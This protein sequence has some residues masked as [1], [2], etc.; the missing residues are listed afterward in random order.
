MGMNEIRDAKGRHK[1]DWGSCSKS[2][3][4]FD[5]QPSRCRLLPFEAEE[6][7]KSRVLGRQVL[8]VG[9]STT[10]QFFTSFVMLLGGR[11]GRNRVRG[12]TMIMLTASACDDEVRLSFVRSDLLLWTSEFSEAQAVARCD[13][14]I[15]NYR[16]AQQAMLDADVFVMAVGQHFTSKLAHAPSAMTHKVYSFFTGNLNRTLVALRHLR[17]VHGRPDPSSVVIVGASLPMPRCE[18]LAQPMTL[19]EALAH[20]SENARYHAYGP[21]YWHSLRLNQLAK[22]LARDAGASFLDIASLSLTRGDD[23]LV[24]GRNEPPDKYVGYAQADCMHYCLPGV[25][26]TFSMLLYNLLQRR[27]SRSSSNGNG[28]GGLAPQPPPLPPKGRY[29]APNVDWLH[30]RGASRRLES[31]NRTCHK[32]FTSI[33]PY[34]S[35]WWWPWR[36]HKGN[37]TLRVEKHK[38]HA[39]VASIPYNESATSAFYKQRQAEMRSGGQEHD[40]SPSSS[41][42]LKGALKLKKGRGRL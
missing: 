38:W 7:C 27:S 32:A 18:R 8:F 23:A 16:W 34:S 36:T 1:H 13:P 33:A 31:C 29:F 39:Y 17:A 40:D 28:G 22:W 11:F 12:S 3:T 4:L 5:W 21:S 37:C 24:R 30:E 9:D 2:R 10:A 35:Y 25:V 19:V 15:F 6:V 20:E 41:A 42:R 14:I 26:D